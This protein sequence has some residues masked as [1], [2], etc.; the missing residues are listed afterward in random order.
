MLISSY[1]C[2]SMWYF[3]LAQPEM[4]EIWTCLGS[5]GAKVSLEVLISPGKIKFY[6]LCNWSTWPRHFEFL[7]WEQAQFL[8]FCFLYSSTHEGGVDFSSSLLF[9]NHSLCFFLSS[10]SSTFFFFKL[11][12]HLLSQTSPTK[13]D[14]LC[15]RDFYAE[16]IRPPCSEGHPSGLSVLNK[17]S[18][19]LGVSTRHRKSS[20]PFHLSQE[21]LRG[22]AENKPCA[23]CCFPLP[24]SLC[25]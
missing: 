4:T 24:L 25:S 13:L 22:R 1:I 11:T 19:K 14:K 16:E 5:K 21:T 17:S 9:F 23:H 7:M 15:T 6:Q 2:I 3:I 20:F 8:A 10:L 12:F 18:D